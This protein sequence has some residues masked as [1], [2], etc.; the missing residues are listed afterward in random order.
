MRELFVKTSG[1]ALA[2]GCLA[3]MSI[4]PAQAPP[5]AAKTGVER[6]LKNIR[7]LTSGGENAEAY[8]SPD[9]TRLIFQSTR[10]GYPCDQIFTVKTDGTDLRRVSTGTGRTTCGY[11]YPGGRQILF[12]STHETSR[13]VPAAPQLRA[14]LRLAD[15]RRLRDLSRERRR[16]AADAADTHARLRRGSDD[17]AGRSHRVHERAR[18]RHGDL[19]DEG[20][21]VGRQAPDRSSRPG[22]RPVFFVGRKAGRVPREAARRRRRARLATGRY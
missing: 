16:F 18:R 5:P 20:G 11:F 15:L 14:R 10:P 2:A 8:F 19:F 22:W 12:A 21:R 6:H 17:R 3:A 13:R 4:E 9:G 7:Q 1:L